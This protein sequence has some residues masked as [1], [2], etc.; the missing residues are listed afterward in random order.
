MNNASPLRGFLSEERFDREAFRSPATD[1]APVYTWMWNAPVTEEET[2]RELEE[3]VSLGIKRLYILPMPKSFRPTSFP[4][5]LSPDY[6]SDDYF[7]AYRYAVKKAKSLGM[8]LWLYDE[9]GWPSGGACG[10]VML[11]DPTLAQQTVRAEERTLRK[12]EIYRPSDEVEIAFRGEKELTKGERLEE[13]AVVT[14]YKRVKTSFPHVASADLPDVTKKGTTELFLKLTH[15]RYQNALGDLPSAGVTALFTDEPTAPRPFPYTQ[16]IKDSF[17]AHFGERIEPYLPLL[18]GKQKATER[19]AKIKIGFF[20]MMSELFC[21]RVLEKQAEWARNAGVAFVGHLDKDD[22]ANGSMTGGNFGLLEALRRFDVPGVDAIRRQIFP[23]KGR[24]GLQGENKFFPRYASSAAAQTGG[25]HA[26]TESFAVYGGG[27]SYDEMRYVLNFQAMR[28]VNVFNLM[29]VPY[30]RTG[31]AQAGLLPHFTPELFPDLKEFN[32]YLSRLSYL[33][34]LGKRV[35]D[36]ALYYPI[37]DGIAEGPSALADYEK[38][39]KTLEKR[40]VLFDVADDEFLKSADRIA[41]QKGVL[42]AGNAKYKRIVLPSCRHLS[43][44]AVDT[45]RAFLDAGGE[46]VTTSKALAEKIGAT[47]LPDLSLLPSARPIEDE[48]ISYA[49]SV[50]S[51]GKLAFL[52]NESGETKRLSL[53][54]EGKAPYLIRPTEG[55]ILSP[56]TH[57]GKLTFDLVSGELV[58]LLFTDREIASKTP[59]S[60]DK[61]LL[62]VDWTYRPTDK[63]T[64]GER[65]LRLALDEKAR[66]LIDAA[67]PFAN[68]F[69]GSVLYATTFSLPRGTKRALLDLGETVGAAEAFLNGASLGV[70][71]MPPYRFEIPADLLQEKN[72]LEVRVTSDAADA[73]LDT[74]AFKGYRP[75]Q[76]GNYFSEELEFCRDRAETGIRGKVT[77]F[78]E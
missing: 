22:E 76:L 36:T 70:K 51:D 61:S 40:G 29:I 4:T 63:L 26:L 9:G 56:E 31:Y 32:A 35:A 69:S 7:R 16:E 17:L 53:S 30:G 64:I 41:L 20:R 6:L 33:F 59:L 25:R 77:L 60:C 2:D 62:L 74:D 50:T 72:A 57:D 67:A 21:D 15:E 47:F 34:S 65:T 23:P 14:E 28:G 11:E 37:E 1:Y 66:P 78:Y 73:Y 54:L 12:G 13:D 27:V 48:E 3:M 43:E 18:L 24:R 10:Q 38:A 42:A 44:C 52:M 46:A 5:P 75:W 71:P 55:D 8:A 19:T 58:A 45:L 49:E 39:G 68:G